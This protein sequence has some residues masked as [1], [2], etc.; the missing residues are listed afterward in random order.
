MIGAGSQAP[1]FRLRI[2]QYRD[3]TLDHY[4]DKRLVVAFYVA[5][6]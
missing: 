3:T 2:G 4:R 1:A 6:W 5:D